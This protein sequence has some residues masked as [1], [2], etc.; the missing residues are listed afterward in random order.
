MSTLRFDGAIAGV[1]T[2]SGTRLVLGMWPVSPFGPIVDVMIEEP[3]GHRVLVAPDADV[4]GWLDALNRRLGIPA[5][6]AA[7]G[8][9][10]ERREWVVERALA[11]HSH[12]TNPRSLTA[13]DYRGLLA[14]AGA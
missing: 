8:I 14:E 5:S 3:A 11:D 6:L 13:D 12:P 4:A 10:P 7:L 9:G 2:A 1:G